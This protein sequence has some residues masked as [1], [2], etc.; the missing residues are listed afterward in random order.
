M[1]EGDRVGTGLSRE[2]AKVT[3]NS[4]GDLLDDL[5]KRMTRMGVKSWRS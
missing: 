2:M 3:L 5:M 4:P 1:D